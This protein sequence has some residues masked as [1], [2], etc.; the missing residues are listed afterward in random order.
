M[1]KVKNK[2]LCELPTQNDMCVCEGALEGGE[3]VALM[4]VICDCFVMAVNCI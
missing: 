3:Y 1:A 2:F 4:I